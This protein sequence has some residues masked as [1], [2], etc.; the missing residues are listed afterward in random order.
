MGM[1][2]GQDC[3]ILKVRP[4]FSVLGRRSLGFRPPWTAAAAAA[5]AGGRDLGLRV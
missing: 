4:L 3:D 5:A 1:A 2:M